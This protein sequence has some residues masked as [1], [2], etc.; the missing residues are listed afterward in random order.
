MFTKQRAVEITAIVT[1][2]VCGLCVLTT[3][4]LR[5]AIGKKQREIKYLHGEIT[6]LQ[7]RLIS[8]Q[9]TTSELDQVKKLIEENVANSE[10]DT[11]AQGASLEFL[12]DLTEVL[13]ALGIK[14][15]TLEPMNPRYEGDFIETPYKMVIESTYKQF[16]ELENKMEKSSRL[17]SLTE[18]TLENYLEEYFNGDK[19]SRDK[20]KISLEL[21]TLTLVREK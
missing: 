2:I 21:T 19:K 4:T 11:L 1:L 3:F 12:K 17:I 10:A 18:F 16:C 20:A 7:K 15:I 13:D 14:L 8:A 6:T 5:G 9:I